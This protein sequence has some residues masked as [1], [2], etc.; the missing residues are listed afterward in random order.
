M[1]SFK[2]IV[3]G[4]ASPPPNLLHSAIISAGG[5]ALK[6]QIHST[7]VIDPSAS[8]GSGVFIGPYCIVGPDVAIGDRTELASHVVIERSTRIGMDC[9]IS[10]H[11]VLGSDAQD[12]SYK[13]GP[14]FLTIGDRNTFR[15]YCIFNRGAHGDAPLTRV[16]SDNFFM[17]G[18]HVAHDCIIGSSTIMANHAT[19]GGHC[20]VEDKVV[21]GGLAAFHQFTR[22]GTMSMIG[23]NA[24]VHS[25]IPPY[26]M[27][28]GATSATLR[29]LN[30]VGLRRN[31]VTAE[32]QRAI[33][34]AYRLMFRRGMTRE[35]A[36]AEIRASVATTPEIMHFLKFVDVQSKRGLASAEAPKAPSDLKVVGKEQDSDAD[37]SAPA[38][39]A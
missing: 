11:S 24:A 2:F 23:G 14:A 3:G 35:N 7:A 4:F 5:V 36:I 33:K 25:D 21:V 8:I 9:K 39:D 16:G 18:V 26:A 27:A 15:E 34:Q 20:I 1:R 17:S 32:S 29:G 28:A 22:V 37:P 10:S 12:L 38:K 31:G 30:M 13:G 19:F 6:P